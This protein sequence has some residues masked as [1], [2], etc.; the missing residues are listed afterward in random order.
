MSYC[1]IDAKSDVY[2]YSNIFGGYDII[3]ADSGLLIHVE[4]LLEFRQT[5]T[6]LKDAGHKVPKSAIERIDRELKDELKQRNRGRE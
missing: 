3:V 1:R 2:A 6:N 4:T 5:L